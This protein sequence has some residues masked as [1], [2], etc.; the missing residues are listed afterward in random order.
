MVHFRSRVSLARWI[1]NS[2]FLLLFRFTMCFMSFCSNHFMDLHFFLF[3]YLIGWPPL[4]Q[5]PWFLKLYYKTYQE[6]LEYC[7][8]LVFGE[9]VAYTKSW[10]Y[11]GNCRTVSTNISRLSNRWCIG[12]VEWI[13]L[14]TMFK[15]EDKSFWR[16]EH[17]YSITVVLQL[18]NNKFR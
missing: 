7:P 9:M 8:N 14:E 10:G 12:S 6:G 3:L 11:L 13:G 15:L 4:I 1:I 2:S 17:C 16:R 5:H 18:A